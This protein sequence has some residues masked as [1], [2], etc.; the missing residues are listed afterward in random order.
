MLAEPESSRRPKHVSDASSFYSSSSLHPNNHFNS[1]PP[2]GSSLLS[3]T[4][5]RMPSFHDLVCLS[6]AP[7]VDLSRQSVQTHSVSE[8]FAL[9]ADPTV[10]G[11]DLL[12]DQP[13][14]DDALHNP[15]NPKWAAKTDHNVMTLRGATN[16]GCLI[17]LVVALLALFLGYPLQAFFTRHIQSTQGGFNAGGINAS[18]QVPSIPNNFGLIDVDT[19]SSAHTYTSFADGAEWQLVF[20]DE[21][22]TAGRTFWPGDDPYWEAVDLHNWQTND[23]EWYTPEAVTTRNGSLEITMSEKAKNGLDYISASL[24]T[25]NKFCFTG[26]LIMASVS[27]PGS[28]S[29]AG[30]W[31][32]IWT[33]GNLGRVGYGATLDGMWPYNYDSCDIGT[34]PNQTHNNGPPY[35]LTHGDPYNDNKLSYLPGQRLSRC[36][37]PGESHP[38]PVH[39]EDGSFVGRSA[40]EIDIFE[41]QVAGGVAG[42]SQSVQYA[43]MNA[44]YKW[45]NVTGN[46]KLNSDQAQLNSYTGGVYQQAVSGTIPTNPDCFTQE[47]GCFST[48]GF[49]YKP[50]YANDSAYITWIADGSAS[51]TLDAAGMQADPLTE[52]NDRPI[53]QE[54]MYIIANLA[55]SQQFSP[56]D[57]A[58]LVFPM[59]MRID[60][61]RVY[62]PKDAINIGCD[63]ADYPTASYIAQYPEA[64]NNPN[65]TTW[66][67]PASAGG[68]DQTMPKNSFLGQC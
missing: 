66:T 61:I 1:P 63:P 35:A 36:T 14:A 2:S 4:V 44:E 56:P 9:P 39:A 42:L 46:Y 40:P 45:K 8:K 10:W 41:A 23:L 16:L 11:S 38:G 57:F 65:L 37:C 67:G 64:Y 17:V 58:D 6:C 32:A 54:P 53:P 60:W 52:I 47:T 15:S 25:W 20:S 7:E 50:G 48:H 27:L 29:V 18:G 55:M 24:S 30:M 22:E 28:S 33:M 49:E 62:Q 59:T 26:G 19:P 21:F 13:E 5:G 34:A 51:W 43:P 68:Y 3:P 31:P 12:M